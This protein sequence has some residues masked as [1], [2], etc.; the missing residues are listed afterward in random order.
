MLIFL[1]YIKFSV[2]I[3]FLSGCL[4]TT[5][6]LTDGTLNSQ[7]LA[8]TQEM[9]ELTRTH[10]VKVSY[11]SNTQEPT[12]EMKFRSLPEVKTFYYA[13][14]NW[15]K[16]DL[17]LD[18]T[19]DSSFFQSTSK[20]LVCGQKNWDKYVESSKLLFKKRGVVERSVYEI[21]SVPTPQTVRPKSVEN[22]LIEA[23]SL[24]D[25]KL[26][27]SQQYDEQVKRILANQ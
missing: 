20:K 6:L 3:P 26:I 19:W 27:T 13:D 25:K 7:D 21:S 15:Y 4:A 24:F 17:L 2:F 9:A 18:G 16:F 23:R 12:N 10:C 11:K 14:D 1:K 5:D 22:R 8:V